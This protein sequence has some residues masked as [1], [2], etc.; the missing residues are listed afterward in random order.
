MRIRVRKSSEIVIQL[1]VLFFLGQG[2][3]FI[4]IFGG[5][6]RYIFLAIVFLYLLMTRW[7]LKGLGLKFTIVLLIYLA[8]CVSTSI[9]SG[10]PFLSL[11]KSL[12]F[13]VTVITMISVGYRWALKNPQRDCFDYLILFVVAAL[14]AGA[15]GR[16]GVGSSS[17]VSGVEIYQGLT[18]NANLLGSIQNM[19]IPFL[20]WALHCSWN[21][22]SQKIKWGLLL[23][24]A[25]VFLLLS[26]SRSSILATTVTFL[27]YVESLEMQKKWLIIMGGIFLSIILTLFLSVTVMSALST[28]IYKSTL[29]QDILRTRQPVWEVSYEQARKG[30]LYGGGFGA[31]IGDAE[32]QLGSEGFKKGY[33]R[34]KGNSQLAIIEE[35]GVVG[36]VLYVLLISI[37]FIKIVPMYFRLRGNQKILLGISVGALLGMLTQSC[38]EAWWSAPG[39]P[40][41]V[42][43]WLMVGATFGV[44]KGI[45]YGYT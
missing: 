14:L 30:G 17:I 15:L 2:T 12:V 21:S 4:D 24:L 11:V 36:F 22:K 5:N 31:T 33:G 8:W 10:V 26:Y 32:Y 1:L 18:G 9:W 13:S 38:I 40:E 6:I 35:T 44:V 45:R 20:L 3:S 28:Y 29:D 42:F 23:L 19:S 43:F 41:T 7:L 37:I 16:L 27:V 39:A 34:E 25:I